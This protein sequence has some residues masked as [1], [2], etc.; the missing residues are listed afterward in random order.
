[1][2][3]SSDAGLAVNKP[4][5]QKSKSSNPDADAVDLAGLS[6]QIKFPIL[7][8]DVNFVQTWAMSKT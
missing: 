3:P 5:S 2:A 1:M 7:N 8:I 4:P 6:H